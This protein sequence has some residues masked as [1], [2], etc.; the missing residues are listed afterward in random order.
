MCRGVEEGEEGLAGG[1]V[2]QEFAQAVESRGEVPEKVGFPVGVGKLGVGAA[3][4]EEA[5]DGGILVDGPPV[6][7][8]GAGLPVIGEVECLLLAWRKLG[9]GVEQKRGEIVLRN[10]LAQALE[11]DEGDLPVRL[12][13]DVAGLEVAVDERAREPR[14]SVGEGSQGGVGRG[15]IQGGGRVAVVSARHVFEKVGLLPAVETRVKRRLQMGGETVGDGRAPEAVELGKLSHGIPVGRGRGRGHRGPGQGAEVGVSEILEPGQPPGRVLGEHRR[16]AQ[17]VPPEEAGEGGEVVV[18][19]AGAT[20]PGEDDGRGIIPGDPPGEP[21]R[22]L[23]RQRG[24]RQGG[25]TAEAEGATGGREKVG[26]RGRE[27]DG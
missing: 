12:D 23:F 24:Q 15:A 9:V 13:E 27:G 2:R 19:L 11:V 7:R 3:G 4:L 17:A 6:F 25:V 14:Q 5:L 1:M 10:P 20:V 18:L 16:D 26:V 22:P 21:V 8:V